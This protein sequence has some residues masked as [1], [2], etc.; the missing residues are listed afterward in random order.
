MAAEDRRLRT[1][2]VVLAGAGAIL[3]LFAVHRILLPFIVAGALAYI[4]HPLIGLL[5]ARLRMGRR[6]AG[7]AVYVL[8]VGAL[9]GAG[10]VIGGIALRD[11]PDLAAQLPQL[12]ERP[13]VRWFGPEIG[14]LGETVRTDELAQRAATRLRDWLTGFPQI[15]DIV[16]AGLTAGFFAVL[17]LVL[18]LYF[19]L[20]GERLARGML[21]LVPPA[22][23]EAARRIAKRVNPVLA[24]Y[25]GG[26][27]AVVIYASFAAWVGIGPVLGLPYAPLLAVMTGFLEVIPV[28]GPIFAA[29]VVGLAAIEQGEVHVIFG[30]FI[31]AVVLRLSID[32]LVGPLF[33]GRAVMLNPAVVIFALLAGGSLAGLVGVLI[34]VPTAAAVKIVLGAIYEDGAGKKQR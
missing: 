3:F 6:T 32:Q 18:F 26:V 12:I 17:S 9:L 1:V 7:L 29:A 20:T 23:R 19:V 28:V 4:A 25:F 2:A 31:Y 10:W 5:Q 14:I 13:L 8:F 30:F 27:A 24:R 34:A 33:L 15:V 11:L 22:H 21:W 16:G